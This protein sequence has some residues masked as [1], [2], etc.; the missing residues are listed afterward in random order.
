MYNYKIV[1]DKINNTGGYGL[2][3]AKAVTIHHSGVVTD[4][5]YNVLER[6]RSYSRAHQGKFPYHFYIPRDFEGGEYNNDILITQWLNQ[7]TVHNTNWDGNRNCLAVCLEGNFEVQQPTKTQLLK[8]KQLLDDLASKRFQIELGFIR[9]FEA[10]NPKDNTTMITFSGVTVPMLHY[11]NEVAQ[12]VNGVKQATACCGKNLIPYVVEYRDKA[13]D[14]DWDGKRE[15]KAVPTTTATETARIKELENE[16]ASLRSQ[17]EEISA[18]RD[19]FANRAKVLSEQA[20]A[21]ELYIKQIESIAKSKDAEINALQAKIAFRETE[22]EK[23]LKENTDLRDALLEEKSKQQKVVEFYDQVVKFLSL[24][25]SFLLLQ[26]DKLPRVV[27]YN[28]PVVLTALAAA[29]SVPELQDLVFSI[30][31]YQIGVQTIV[32][33]LKGAVR[34]IKD[35]TELGAQRIDSKDLL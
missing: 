3:K 34:E 20:L 29:L 19:E 5:A 11:H 6:L 22:I 12:V 35:N 1:A 24:A 15:K 25:K 10:V 17:I 4:G 9:D 32:A 18:K 21:S 33:L 31:G 26:F 7:W 8:L 14:V 28:I 13:G 27:K 30:A 23:I 16:I 2:F